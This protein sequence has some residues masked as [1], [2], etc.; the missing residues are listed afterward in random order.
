MDIR[1]IVALLEGANEDQGL[2]YASGKG[3]STP[4]F[5]WTRDT[6]E[7]LFSVIELSVTSRAKA[8]SCFRRGPPASVLL[9]GL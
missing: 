7:K 1:N 8:D 4:D 5:A 6:V 2:R 3:A 9:L